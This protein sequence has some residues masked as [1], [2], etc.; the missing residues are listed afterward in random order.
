MC[1]T[2][3]ETQ[4]GQS[5]FI[6]LFN[7]PMQQVLSEI[8]ILAPGRM[9]KHCAF[10][11]KSKHK[12]IVLAQCRLCKLKVNKLRKC[13]LM[14]CPQTRGSNSQAEKTQNASLQ[15]YMA[16]HTAYTHQAS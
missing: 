8:S 6:S 7:H 4:L 16:Q 11:N 15:F 13:P 2:A 5:R 10:G 9:P 12:L 14:G 3:F 1:G